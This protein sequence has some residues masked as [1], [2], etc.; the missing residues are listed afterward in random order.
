MI[1]FA[2]LGLSLSGGQNWFNKPSL[3]TQ[4]IRDHTTMGPS[5]EQ[6]LKNEQPLLEQKEM[7]KEKDLSDTM[8][9]DDVIY[10]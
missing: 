2:L 3:E 5:V 4:A 10:L 7:Q 1:F 8:K 9:R 6:I